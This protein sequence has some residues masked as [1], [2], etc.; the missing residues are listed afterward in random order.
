MLTLHTVGASACLGRPNSQLVS[1]V[2]AIRGCNT[3]NFSHC[4]GSRESATCPFKVTQWLFYGTGSS[5]VQMTCIGI[6][7]VQMA[8]LQITKIQTAFKSTTQVHMTLLQVFIQ[9]HITVVSKL[10]RFQWLFYR[11]HDGSNNSCT[12]T[13]NFSMTLVP[14][15]ETSNDITVVYR[16][17]E[18]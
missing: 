6:M 10:Q 2:S 11:N 7:N 9:F 1:S 5:T 15:P 4:R 17:Y 3:F 14:A 16:Y 8:A 13:T 18:V 12:G